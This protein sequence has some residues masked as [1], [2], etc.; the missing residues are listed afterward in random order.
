M[1]SII[2]N[3][4]I[5]KIKINLNDWRTNK[6]RFKYI[7]FKHIQNFI[8]PWDFSKIALNLIIVDAGKFWYE[9][10]KQENLK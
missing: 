9:L 1:N 6:I 2:Y 4:Y 10:I 8:Q 3:K 5:N 7:F